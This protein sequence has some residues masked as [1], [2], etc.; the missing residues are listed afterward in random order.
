MLLWKT[1]V[2]RGGTHLYPVD[3]SVEKLFN[4]VESRG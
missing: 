1:D 2:F 4:L 3:M